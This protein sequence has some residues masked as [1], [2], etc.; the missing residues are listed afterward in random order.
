[1]KVACAVVLSVFFVFS[2]AVLA[3][4]VLDLPVCEQQLVKASISC[5]NADTLNLLEACIVDRLA[6]SSCMSDVSNIAD[7]D[8]DMCSEGCEPDLSN[9]YISQ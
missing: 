2:T 5:Q 3:E 1:M 8:V 9:L 6:Q 4:D 7:S